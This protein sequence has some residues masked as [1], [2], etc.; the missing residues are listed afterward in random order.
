MEIRVNVNRLR[1]GA[2]GTDRAAS[3]SSVCAGWG[4]RDRIPPRLL[5]LSV[6][7]DVQ[8]P[9]PATL[10]GWCFKCASGTGTWI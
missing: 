5:V 1:E 4:E 2:A 8:P 6:P 7:F 3:I 10:S 9:L